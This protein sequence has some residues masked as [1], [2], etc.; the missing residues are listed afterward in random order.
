MRKLLYCILICNLLFMLSALSIL[1]H[2]SRVVHAATFQAAISSTTL[3]RGDSGKVSSWT[4]AH[5]FP[6][7]GPPVSIELTF[8]DGPNPIYTPLILHILARYHIHATF[9]T[10]GRQVQSYPSLVRQEHQQEDVV[11]NHSWNHPDLTRLT[12]Q[13]IHTQL[14]ATSVVI[15]RTTGASPLFFRPPYGSTNAQVRRVAS[16]LGLQQILWTIDTRDWQ[17]PGVKQIVHTVL[18]QAT[19]GCIILMHDGGG[20]RSQTV[21]ALPLI[22]T[23]LLQRGFTFTVV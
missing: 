3:G 17:Q 7:H 2:T 11:G 19:N 21:Q 12:P 6:P 9:F 15:Q 16:Q 23:G 10:I 1:T 20:N 14:Q 5:Y 8:D 22:I 18:T 13:A 4:N